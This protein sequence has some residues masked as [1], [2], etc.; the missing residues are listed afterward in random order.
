[1]TRPL[2]FVAL[3]ILTLSAQEIP[4]PAPEPGKRLT[5]PEKKEPS[6]NGAGI[7][8]VRPGAELLFRVASSG[9]RPMRFT[10]TGLP[11]GVSL[12]AATGI[13]TGSLAEEGNYTFT[14][15]AENAKGTA[16]R[17]ITICVGQTLCLTP[18][19]GWNSWYSH[20][21]A[22]SQREV[23]LAAEH[24]HESGLGNH[25][26]SYVNIDDCWQGERGGAE[27]ALQANAQFPSM[28]K[29]CATI[30]AYGF[31]AGIY[32]TP[33]L[34]TYEGFR[35]G[36]TL[37]DG[38]A[39]ALAIP[40]D[41]RKRKEQLFGTYPGTLRHG[42]N[43]VGPV[44]KVDVDARQWAQWGF[45]YV[46]MDWHPIDPAHAERIARDLT[47][48]GRD[49]VLSLSNNAN[50]ND[51]QAL[52]RHAH[53]VRTTGDIRDTWESIR[54]ILLSQEKW[55]PLTRPG[56]WNDP[57][58]LQ[59]GL[60]GA[61]NMGNRGFRPTRLTPD[62][63]YTQIS[64]WCLLS[65]P[66][67]LSTDLSRLDDFTLG[68]LT[69]DEVLAVNQDVAGKAASYYHLNGGGLLIA[70]ELA[71]GSTAVG[72]INLNNEKSVFD[73]FGS[74]LPLK[75]TYDVRD[76]WRQQN[77]GHYTNSFPVEVNPHGCSLFRLTPTEF[78]SPLKN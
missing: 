49:I 75:G 53:T 19:M 33:W 3:A 65:A 9:E 66:L 6:I 61:P 67:L 52:S 62:E 22:I 56:Y 25:G 34:G 8:G 47:H 1:M 55:V 36:S 2:L 73:I 46:K 41:Q 37:P 78:R 71:D 11:P 23:E 21:S 31:K 16:E 28:D 45:D 77:V 43:K 20:G 5:P 32:S 69:N 17:H 38:D 15:K 64:A 26:W 27:H 54:S 76:L 14:V 40:Q 63:Q 50:P 39:E 68:L 74:T 60:Q 42:A 58:M 29:L 30:H 18:P 57:D 10:A 70:K 7:W 51:G 59:V 72:I 4:Y 13:I 48:C 12:D 44:W 35:G 24:L